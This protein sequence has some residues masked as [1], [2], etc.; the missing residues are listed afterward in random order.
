[1]NA[2][3]SVLVSVLAMVVAIQFGLNVTLICGAAAYLLAILLP[4]FGKA[5]S[6]ACWPLF[7]LTPKAMLR[8]F[9]KTTCHRRQHELL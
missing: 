1:M 4:T 7:C 8:E 3:S 6:A 2:A 5:A 9:L